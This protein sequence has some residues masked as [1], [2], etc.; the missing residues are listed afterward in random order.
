MSTPTPPDNATLGHAAPGLVGTGPDWLQEAQRQGLLPAGAEI[1][2]PDR[3]WPVQLLSALGA[4]LAI[5]PFLV[6]LGLF[7]GEAWR[8]GP[9]AYLMGGVLLAAALGLLRNTRLSGFMEQLGLPFLILG[10]CSLGYALSRDLPYRVALFASLAVCAGLVWALPRHWLRL[11]IGVAGAWQLM[12]MVPGGNWGDGATVLWWAV[13]TALAIWAVAQLV[14][15]ARGRAP[16]GGAVAALLEPVLRG[17]ALG[18]LPALAWLSGPSF[19]MSGALGSGLVRSL[20][21]VLGP[22]LWHPR[23]IGPALLSVG[24]TGL[25][26]AALVRAWPALRLRRLAVPLALLLVLAWLLPAWGACLL[27]LSLSMIRGRRVPALAAAATALWVLGT[28]YYRLDLPLTDKALVLVA[29]GALLGAWLW[30]TRGRRNASAAASEPA[31]G[32]A[33]ARAAVALCGVLTL[34]VVNGLIWQKEDLIA[35]GRPVFV[36]LAPMDPRSLMQGD[37]MRINY[38]LPPTPPVAGVAGPWQRR[39]RVAAALDAR[40]VLQEAHL[41]DA[42]EAPGAGEQVL[43]LSP[44]NGRWTLV[45]DAW[46][47]E[48]GQEPVFRKATHGEFRVLPDGR[49]LLVGLTDQDLRRLP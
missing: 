4:W 12:A 20:H 44:V 25:A 9:T 15:D 43:E 7:F 14:V 1:A 18:L 32:P 10:L 41:L 35:H 37:F 23:W 8:N 49:A 48:E 33:G 40:G 22:H 34:G 2:R 42:N 21:D 30:L 26:A 45:S 27:V 16:G 46:F 13:Y 29:A 24:C 39:P 5:V 6:F 19:M 3:P 47:F 17:W 38:A 31:G 36:K 28:F 11:L